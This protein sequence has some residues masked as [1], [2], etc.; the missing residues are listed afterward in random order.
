MCY[1]M[2]MERKLGKGQ[3]RLPDG[4]IVLDLG[5]ALRGDQDDFDDLDRVDP[6]VAE[7]LD[8][9]TSEDPTFSPPRGH[10]TSG[11]GSAMRDIIDYKGRKNTPDLIDRI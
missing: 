2:S 3:R 6:K 11:H 1:S 8:E 9:E 10:H 5:I 7:I 4:R